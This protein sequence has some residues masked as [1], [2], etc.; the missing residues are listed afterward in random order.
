M[1]EEY[2]TNVRF[3]EDGKNVIKQATEDD[4]FD[5]LEKYLPR[6]E[7]LCIYTRDIST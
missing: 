3:S 7:T 5:L 6:L 4:F 1:S 2:D